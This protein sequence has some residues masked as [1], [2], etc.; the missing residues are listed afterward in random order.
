[1]FVFQSSAKTYISGTL[2]PKSPQFENTRTTFLSTLN[3]FSNIFHTQNKHPEIVEYLSTLNPEDIINI[4]GGIKGNKISIT[5]IFSRIG[6]NKNDIIV[7]IFSPGKTSVSIKQEGTL[8]TELRRN[9][10][11]IKVSQK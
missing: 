3:D 10:K 4:K 1:M 5:A 6:A 8:I 9:G 7:Q 11:Q 2:S